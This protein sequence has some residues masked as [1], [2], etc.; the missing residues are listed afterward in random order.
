MSPKED[1]E[2]KGKEKVFDSTKRK[3]GLITVQARG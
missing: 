3:K 2:G 1:R